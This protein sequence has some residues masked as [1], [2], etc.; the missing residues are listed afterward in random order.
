MS[1]DGDSATCSRQQN[2]GY[3]EEIDAFGEGIRS[4]VDT[5]VQFDDH[6]RALR[7]TNA[8]SEALKALRATLEAGLLRPVMAYVNRPRADVTPLTR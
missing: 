2:S 5:I 7:E 6:E 1:A 4:T 8:A 3:S